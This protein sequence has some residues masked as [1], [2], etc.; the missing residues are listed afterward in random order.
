M[1]KEEKIITKRKKGIITKNQILETAAQMFA[2][3]GYDNVS[4][5][6]IAK[7]V[8]VKESSL[9]NHFKCKKDILDVLLKEFAVR[10]QYTRPTYEQLEKMMSIMSLEE[11]LKNIMFSVGR[12]IDAILENTAIIIQ[13][14]KFRN[15]QAAEAYYKYLVIEPAAYYQNLIDMM[16][17]KEMIKYK[18]VQKII[19][20]YCY[21]ATAVSQEFFMAKQ[22][23]GSI[24]ESV[25]RMLETIEFFCGILET[26]NI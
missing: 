5:R 11:I 4:I 17:Q 26:K 21:T 14:E 25:K 20:Q 23:Y 10:A 24:E 7:G 19:T 1:E 6:V 12:N 22:G 15:Q 9:Y 13:S 2:F 3:K 18:N 8:G 16:N